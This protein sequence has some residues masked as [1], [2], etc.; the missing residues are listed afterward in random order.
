VA[1]LPVDGSLLHRANVPNFTAP[2]PTGAT[3]NAHPRDFERNPSVTG[4]AVFISATRRDERTA[5]SAAS[6]AA[7]DY[8]ERLT[9]REN[10]WL[11]HSLRDG[12]DGGRRAVRRSLLDAP[13]RYKLVYTEP[14]TGAGDVS[15]ALRA[16][17]IGLLAFGLAA[18]AIGAARR[19]ETTS[20]SALSN[21]NGD[22]RALS[23]TAPT[24][25]AIAGAAVLSAALVALSS[26]PGAYTFMFIALL[27]AVGFFYTLRGGPRAIRIL[28][29]AVIAIAPFR[30]A[31]LALADAIDLPNPYLTFNALQPSLIAACAAAV[32][33]AHR[34][35]LRDEPRVLVAAWAA[36]AAA[37]AL[38]LATQTVGL[39][40]YAIGVAQYLAYPTF[41]LL[42]WP[43]LANRD[44]EWLVW[45]LAALGVLVA[46]SIFLEVAGVYF[47]ES[48][49]INPSRFGGATGSV[50]H[51]A[52]FLGTT[53]VLTLGVLFARW[54][55]SNALWTVVAVG[56]MLGAV[57]LTSSRGGLAV[58]AVGGLVLFVALSGR[59]RLRLLVVATLA[60]A[61]GLAL[62]LA[63]SPDRG[64]LASRASASTSLGQYPGN[65]QR[66]E[67][68]RKDI[69][70][71]W[72][73]PVAEKGFGA[74]L[75]STGNAKKLTS[76]EP[77]ATES[78]PLKLLLETGVVGLLLIGSVLIWA[79]LL[80][81][82][83]AWRTGDP[84]LKGVGAAGIGLFAESLI[85][86][87][88]EVQLL[89]LTW[90]LLLV[91]CLPARAKER[92]DPPEQEHRPREAAISA[93]GHP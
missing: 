7:A 37:A 50:L 83:T 11:R 17:L 22:A 53:A 41:A 79:V 28:L 88:L 47:T 90:W 70:V 82:R 9:A 91:L 93:V 21:V 34:W 44:R 31:L 33:L 87:A 45:A 15:P 67:T 68:M 23:A 66:L 29:I 30:G 19:R 78:Y 27:A 8:V 18:A 38:D 72:A 55:R 48:V 14:S 80:F 57:A 86:Q 61:L 3:L 39:Q 25:V 32:L 89:S 76:R 58:V 26:S 52:I 77:E 69:K 63:T 36:I 92:A 73:L 16:S 42:V 6:G 43:L 75:A 13:A 85:Y 84:V 59:N 46:V 81:V 4:G 35:M 20:T 60:T 65:G 24:A 54:S 40:L 62:S 51:A 74:G 56:V 71:F 49:T 64:E 5:L 1:I 10:R 2:P 12:R